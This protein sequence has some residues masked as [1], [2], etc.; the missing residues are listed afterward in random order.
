M[1]C[2]FW[3]ASLKLLLGQ[4]TLPSSGTV[5][6]MRSSSAEVANQIYSQWYTPS[7]MALRMALYDIAQPVG[8][9]LSGAM[10]GGL[11]TNFEGLHGRAGW[12]W[13]FIINVSVWVLHEFNTQILTKAQG[14]CTIAIA[15]VAF[16]VL[17]G[18]VSHSILSRTIRYNADTCAAWPSESI[19]EV[20]SHTTEPWHRPWTSTSSSSEA[21]IWL[22]CQK[23]LPL[24]HVLAVMG[25]WSWVLTPGFSAA[26]DNGLTLLLKVAWPF[27]NNSTPSKYF[28][29][30]L[31]SL[32]NPDGTSK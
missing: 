27:G 32:T 13:A 12:R 5:T 16:F 4:D 1:G 25:V 31:K 23:L 3:L 8:A 28:N 26:N 29:L 2:V 7:E 30:W 15:L 6:V 17:P 10:Q 11:S 18:F 22:H 9:M 21:S 14:V 20:L 24:F 19:S